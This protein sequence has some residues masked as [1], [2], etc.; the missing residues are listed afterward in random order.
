MKA[1]GI[2][3]F[4]EQ[5]R[6]VAN[7]S[8]QRLSKSELQGREITLNGAAGDLVALIDQ[9]LGNAATAPDQ[10]KELQ[11]KRLAIMSS[12]HPSDTWEIEVRAAKI[13]E[14]REGE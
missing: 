7:M 1:E 13:I 6:T 14:A 10:H 8:G 11:D 3:P 9:G 5:G 4:S 12:F 2:N